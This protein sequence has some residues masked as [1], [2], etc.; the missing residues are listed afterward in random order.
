MK[1]DENKVD[2]YI[3]QKEDINDL[4]SSDRSKRFSIVHYIQSLFTSVMILYIDE[5]PQT[6]EKIFDNFENL[7]KM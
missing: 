1:D 3:F 6:R 2:Y 5:S 7:I 4:A